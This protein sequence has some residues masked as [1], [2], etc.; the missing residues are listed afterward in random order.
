MKVE[1]WGCSNE[2]PKLLERTLCARNGRGRDR[3]PHEPGRVCLQ[4]HQLRATFLR[5]GKERSQYF[6]LARVGWACVRVRGAWISD[7][8]G[9]IQRLHNAEAGRLHPQRAGAQT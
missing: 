5:E 6:D 3:K 1:P 4:R 8:P 7:A 2:G 9:G